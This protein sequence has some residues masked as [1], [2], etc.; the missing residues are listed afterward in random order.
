MEKSR[1]NKVICI[2][3]QSPKF[4]EKCMKDH[5][6]FRKFLMATYTMFPEIFPVD[7]VY[8]FNFHDFVTSR[9][10]NGFSMRRIRLKNNAVYQV[11]PSFMM[12]YMIAVTIEVEK[13]LFLRRWGVPFEALAYVFG[14]DAMYWQ[15][16]YLSIGRNSIVGTTIK[17]LER[18]PDD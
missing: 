18:L 13:A 2:N 7:F 6:E 4:Y 12:P 8:G 3:F 10:Q 1:R 16:A 17:S 14:R 11:R 5:E 9:K 15:R